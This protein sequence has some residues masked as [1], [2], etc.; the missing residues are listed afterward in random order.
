M[1]VMM[2]PNPHN[3]SGNLADGI[4][5]VVVNYA[6]HLPE[7][8]IELV[9]PDADDFDLIACHA[10]L[11]GEVND[12]CHLHGLH[13]SGD[14]DAPIW[15]YR[16]NQRITEAVQHASQITVPSEWVAETIRRDL[17]VNPTVIPHGIDW[18]DWQHDE[19]RG[20][21]VLWNKNR[22][23]DYVCDSS[24]VVKLANGL[25]KTHFVTTFL[26]KH[27]GPQDNIN[28]IGLIPH[29]QMKRLVQ[30]CIV[31]LSTTK[32]T[33]GIGIL[34]AMASGVPILG[35]AHGGILEMVEH[36]VNGYLVPP[37]D[38]EG[39]VEGL[40]YCVEHRRVL[41][42]NSAEMARAWTW[43]AACAKVADVYREVGTPEP[44]TVGVVIPVY[45]KSEEEVRRAVESVINQTYEGLTTITVVDDGSKDES[46]ARD[47]VQAWA[48]QDGRIQLVRQANA[49]VAVAR[50]VGITRA[51]GVK[52]ICCLDAD[53]WIE[54]DFLQVCVQ[55]LESDRSLGVAYTGLQWH[56]PDGSTGLSEWPGQWD[57]DA[58]LQ[59]RNQIPTCCVF[60]RVMWERLGGYRQRYAPRGA[61][62]EDAEYWL[63][64]G[65]YGFKAALVEPHASI[66]SEYHKVTKDL[67]RPPKDDEMGRA[68]DVKWEAVKASLFNYS[69]MSGQVTGDSEY[70]EVDWT[71]WHPWTRDG[72]HPFASYAKPLKHAHPVRA[73]D[74]PAVSV[75]I[76]VGPGHETAVIDA[77]DSLA[78][79]TFRKWE[80]IVVWDQGSDV[81]PS[82]DTTYPYVYWVTTDKVGAGAARN[83]GAAIARAPLLL[84]LDADDWLYPQ[85][86][87]KMIAA[88]NANQAIVYTD[89]VGKA[90]VEPE[91]VKN[92]A[93]DL[94]SKLYHYDE[95]KEEA[96][97]GY[98]AFD[99]DCE[100]IMRQPELPEPFIW[101]N[102]TSIVPRLW[103][104]AIG[105]FDE[106]MPSWEDYDY[107]L[108]LAR[109]GHCYHHLEEELMVYRFYT[110]GRREHGRQI[111][112]SLV[113]YIKQ[114]YAEEGEPMGCR[115]C[116]GKK[117][118]KQQTPVP[119]MAPVSVAQA[120]TA[121]TPGEDSEFVLVKYVKPL[122]GMH[123]VKGLHTTNPLTNLPFDYGQHAY[124][125]VF[126]VH[127]KD[128]Y[129]TDRGSGQRT[130]IDNRFQPIEEEQVKLPPSE[131][132]PTPPPEPLVEVFDPQAWPGI[133]SRVAAEMLTRFDSNEAVK[134][135]GI[136]GLT[137]VPG[138]GPKTARKVLEYLN[139]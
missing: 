90:I 68:Y 93:P 132:E 87:H 57:Y 22:H 112:K 94:Q 23:D 107:H 84:F 91:K 18:A 97:I 120:T 85:A 88:W 109:A 71:R 118:A 31:Y 45:N 92:L 105:G 114:K 119:A 123:G 6:R 51:G 34:E 50:N 8:D 13:W 113:Q 125:H 122:R 30:S 54:P 127:W 117:A 64:A 49:G 124:G 44:A 83:R 75:I 98:K 73:Y 7:F 61:G 104:D 62:A 38:V 58:Q 136:E 121:S 25:T 37:G 101:C 76:P 106:R 95:R 46:I 99:F 110:G 128:V 77:L 48:V 129:G 56:K 20:D 15:E 14:Y 17:R 133:N 130:I 103:H 102:I 82:L 137:K 134:E 42:A 100:R 72:Q 2:I 27:V 81:P 135:A 1:R 60:R 9:K 12:V 59:K 24:P 70:R 3:V 86:L 55:A 115:G 33:F 138:I 41:G 139:Q 63:R 4:S 131:P 53:D 52:Y 96:V 29:E 10:G 67:K 74:K 16:V 80:A 111:N 47:I 43:Q 26:P 89:Y 35:Y 126:T 19:P 28:V 65:A 32:E 116:P 108:R 69:W 79:Q 36:G 78:A 11:T 66:L 39:L 40:R 5:Q 21:Y